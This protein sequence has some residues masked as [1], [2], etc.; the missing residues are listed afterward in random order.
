MES[1][2]SIGL[3]RQ[4]GESLA[5]AILLPALTSV[6]IN[7][8]GGGGALVVSWSDS[9]GAAYYHVKYSDTPG[10]TGTGA[11][12]CLVAAPATSCVIKGLTGGTTYSVNVTAKNDIGGGASVSSEEGS[13]MPIDPLIMTGAITLNATTG[14]IG[15]NLSNGANTYSVKYGTESGVY[16]TVSSTDAYSPFT[17]TGLTPGSTYYVVVTATN[18]SGEISSTTE[19]KMAMVAAPFAPT[20]LLASGGTSSITLNWSAATGGGTPSY[21]IYRGSAAGGPYTVIAT[22]VTNTTYTD[23]LVLNGTTYYYV[24]AAQNQSGTS[25]Q[26]NEVSA[27]PIAL[28]VI[29]SIAVSPTTGGSL[30]LSWSAVTGATGYSVK[31]STTSGQATSGTSGCSTSG[32]SCTVTGLTGGTPY[33]LSLV[34]TN[35]VGWGAS[36]N[37]VESTAIPIAA[38]SFTLVPSNN[39][40]TANFSAAGATSFDLSYGTTTGVYPNSLPNSSTGTE[41]TGLTNGT[42]YFFI[43]AAK[44]AY[45]TLTTAESNSTPNGPAPFSLTSVTPGDTT[46]TVKWSASTGATGY[47]IRYGTASGTYT[48]TVN[49]GT[50]TTFTVTGL[51]NGTPYYFMVTASNAN[52]TANSASE[53]SATPLALPALAWSP[54]TND[55][56]SVQIVTNTAPVTFTLSNNGNGATTGCSAPTIS[57]TSDFTITADTCG[58]ASLAKGASCTVS[59]RANPATTGAKTAT[60]TRACTSSGGTASTTANGITVTGVKPILAFSPLTYDFGNVYTGTDTLTKTFGFANTG[61]GPAKGCSAPQL[62]DSTQFTIIED[63]CGTA[64]LA[65]SAS[66]SVTLRATPQSTG[67]KSTTLSRACT[68]GG[69]TATNANA[70]VMTSIAKAP[71]L[72]WA[73][74]TMDFGAVT[75]GKASNPLIAS[76]VNNGPAAGTGCDAAI[77][78]NVV[79]FQVVSDSCG[80]SD[81]APGSVC[82]IAIQATPASAGIKNATLSRHCTVGGSITTVA[83]GLSV[84]GRGTNTTALSAVSTSPN[85]SHTC[86]VLS[87]GSVQCWGYNAS[88][89]IGDGTTTNRATA[90]AVPGISNAVAVATGGSHSCAL[91]QD[92]TLKC[93][94]VN[95]NGQLGDGTTTNRTAPVAVSG[96]STAKAISLGTSHSCALLIDNSVMCWGL[97]ASGQIGDNTKTNRLTPVAVSGLTAVSDIRA[98][99][100]HS[101]ALLQDGTAKCWGNNANGELGDGTLVLKTVPTV[102][103]GLS[104]VTSLQS[105]SN[106]NCALLNTGSVK[107]WGL[108]SSGQLGDGTTTVRTNAVAITR[109]SG[110]SAI[111]L[112]ANFSCAKLTDNSLKCW[113]ND[114]VGQLGDGTTTH[115]PNPITASRV[116][117]ISSL[118]AGNAHVCVTLPDTSVKC[119]GQ[120]NFNQLGDG[121]TPTR[122]PS[123]ATVPGISTAVAATVGA[124]HTCALLA[125]Q[126]VL[127]WG[128]NA[129]GQLGD[130]TTLN[131][132]TPIAASTLTLGAT[133]I[134][135]GT[136]HTCALLT[137]GTVQCFGATTP[138]AKGERAPWAER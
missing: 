10:G 125:D 114:S 41:I 37:S 67:S 105:G 6:A 135:A 120:N 61:T 72:A 82:E 18:A 95:T 52:G 100:A 122:H 136:S 87:N 13:G 93:W 38:P 94:G 34:A 22:G 75:A 91:L 131:R 15:W 84:L 49:A 44:N 64:D 109:L 26:S 45:G 129:S 97:N 96:I 74:T 5:S 118:T 3:S 89:Q 99:T 32:T 106:H 121:L 79:D 23:L 7:D 35:A 50:A 101:C 53:L 31:Y 110:A 24:V 12:G 8:T 63:T 134:A 103:T 48:G 19:G 83:N 25:P 71:E 107:C 76:F 28:P 117:Q 90:T 127:C 113:G 43:L 92:S 65:A 98:S 58:T 55:F 21:K 27:R 47:Q 123:P 86:A 130:G 66:C 20:S 9:P 33:F 119:W 126:S 4:T 88:G 39:K 124:S 111:A 108:N 73:D 14:I 54:L 11:D 40:I 133:A 30:L 81:S 85:S 29:G 115:A 69:T 70:I 138:W 132:F 116:S 78:S 2:D 46:A 1:V 57:N 112:G 128:A 17:L 42:K 56:G 137:D 80:T 36:S 59:I 62:S 51:T 102:V 16:S 77:L 104:G 60:L 68:T